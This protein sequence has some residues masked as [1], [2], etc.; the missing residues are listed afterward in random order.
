MAESLSLENKLLTTLAN[1]PINSHRYPGVFGMNPRSIILVVVALVVAGLA[2]MLMR[3]Y[4]GNAQQTQVVQAPIGPKILVAAVD[5]PI[6]KFIE[7]ADLRWQSWPDENVSELYLREGVVR[8]TDFGGHVVRHGITAGEP[9]TRARVVAPGVRGFLAAVLAPGMRAVT[10][11]VT[12]ESSVAGLVFPGD[13][14]D[15]ILTHSVIDDSG[16]ARSVGETVFK[17]VRVLAV[18]ASTDDQTNTP[19]LGKSITIEVTPKLAQEVAVVRRLGS[20]SLSLRSLSKPD[21][22]DT[23]A[24]M[25][26]ENMPYTDDKTVSWDADVSNL[27]APLDIGSTRHQVIISRGSSS[28]IVEFKRKEK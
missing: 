9:V 1:N 20:I 24:L 10:I 6:G 18:D 3:N 27:V 25:R 22:E 15:L 19:R 11:P 28:E 8:L 4:L 17:N 2:A 26:D 13:R 12:R 5:L 7:G 21:G 16:I 14:V 23:T